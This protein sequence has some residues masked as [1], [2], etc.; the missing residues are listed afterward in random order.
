MTMSILPTCMYVYHMYARY[1]LMPEEGIGSSGIGVIETGEPS[2]RCWESNP[3]TLEEQP[4]LF[5]AQAISL[6]L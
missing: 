4:G 1:S 3:R 6:G 5:N 2:C